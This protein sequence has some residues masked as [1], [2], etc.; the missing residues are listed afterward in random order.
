M[1]E[2]HGGIQKLSSFLESTFE[3]PAF[4]R[5]YAWEDAQV[6]DFWNDVSFA[7]E[8][9]RDHF[10]GS[11]ILLEQ[12]PDTRHWVIDGQQRLTTIFILLALVRDEMSQLSDRMLAPLPGAGGIPFEIDRQVIDDLFSDLQIGEPRFLANEAIAQSFF[13]SVLRNPSDPD[14]VPFKKRDKEATRR[15]RKAYARL[16]A[17]VSEHFGAL[18]SLDMQK[19]LQN[20]FQFYSR[21][22]ARLQILQITCKDTQ[23]AIEVYMT[24][25]SRGLG[26]RQ[27]DLV[28][29]LLM[30]HSHQPAAAAKDWDF[31]VDSVGDDVDQFLRYYLIAYGSSSGPV[32]SKQVFGAFEDQV[33]RG[34]DG[35]AGSTAQAIKLLADL[36]AKSRVFSALLGRTPLEEPFESLRLT[37]AGMATILDSYRVLLMVVLDEQIQMAPSIRMDLVR[38]TEALAMRWLVAGGNAQTLETNFQSWARAIVSDGTEGAAK[39]LDAMRKEFPSAELVASRLAEPLESAA[40]VRFILFRLNESLTG[41]NAMVEFDAK[42]AQVEHIAPKVPTHYWYQALEC[43]DDDGDADDESYDFLMELVG[44]KTLLDHKINKKIQNDDWEVKLQGKRVGNG[45]A[46]PGYKDS[47]FVGLTVDLLKVADWNAH[48]IQRRTMWIIECFEKVWGAEPQLS[49]LKRYVQWLGHV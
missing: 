24:L 16:E 25:N 11:V 29:S 6:D 32:K 23:E 49:E 28:K 7:V 13:N 30:K 40:L 39:V 33:E 19:T 5:N 45:N 26:L 22:L 41:D 34:P 3:V 31:I 12:S 38:V 27:S 2:A 48:Q 47:T 20:Y 17:R 42:R 10:L 46:G 8:N 18:R 36:K 43:I 15:L 44:N 37:I 4:Q 1:V 21:L 35:V 9:N 14:R